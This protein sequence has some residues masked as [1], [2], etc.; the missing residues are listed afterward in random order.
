MYLD[1][2]HDRKHAYVFWANPLGVQLDGIMT[3][4]Q[5]DDY[6]FNTVWQ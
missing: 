1:T 4:G 2:F 5:E 6:S 3:E